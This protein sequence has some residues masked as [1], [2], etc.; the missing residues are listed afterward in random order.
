MTVIDPEHFTPEMQVRVLQEGLARYS[1]RLHD[2]SK[3]NPEALRV[4]YDA[5]ANTVLQLELILDRIESDIAR[6]GKPFDGVIAQ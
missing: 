1:A 4:I 5:L 6:Q 2:I 3:C